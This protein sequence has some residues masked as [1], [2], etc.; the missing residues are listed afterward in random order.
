[1]PATVAAIRHDL[2]RD[3][4]LQRYRTDDGFGVPDVA[5]TLCNFWLVEVHAAFAVS[6]RW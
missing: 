4:W 5:F 6:P 1:M 3:G 2:E